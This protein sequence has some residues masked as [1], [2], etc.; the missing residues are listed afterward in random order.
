MPSEFAHALIPS[1][2]IEYIP[3]CLTS[4]GGEYMR[5]AYRRRNAG[6]KNRKGLLRWTI[7][8][9]TTIEKKT[10]MEGSDG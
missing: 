2:E 10:N 5:S 4:L 1:S 9:Y 3:L 6:P 8:P 7:P